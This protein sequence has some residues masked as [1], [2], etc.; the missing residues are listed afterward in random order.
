GIP[1]TT[2]ALGRDALAPR[3]P[4]RRC[5][6]LAGGLVLGDWYLCLAEGGGA[7]LHRYASDEPERN[8]AAHEPERVRELTDLHDSIAAWALWAEHEGPRRIAALAAR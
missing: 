5:A 6:F 8:L 1:Y 2:D 3:A 4:E 7:S